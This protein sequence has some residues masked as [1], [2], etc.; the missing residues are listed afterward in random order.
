MLGTFNDPWAGCSWKELGVQWSDTQPP[1]IVF[2]YPIDGQHAALQETLRGQGV[3]GAR[4]AHQIA[5]VHPHNDQPRHP[6]ISNVIV[7]ASG[8]GGV[9]KSTVATHLALALHQEGA[10]VGLL[11][12]DIYGPSQPLTMGLGDRASSQGGRLVPL[13]RFGIPVMSLGLLVDANT[14]TIWRGPMATQALQQMFHQSTWPAL[15]YLV[16]DMPPGTGD[17]P[18]TLAQKLPLSAAIL[19]STPQQMAWSDVVRGHAMFAKLSVPV[20]GVVANMA[21]HTCTACGHVDPVFGNA[22]AFQ[23]TLKEAGLPC[24]AEL[25][26]SRSI[27]EASDAGVPLLIS[28]PDSAEA[29]A[30]T[31][32]ARRVAARLSLLPKDRRLNTP[33]RLHTSGH[34]EH[35]PH[36]H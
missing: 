27:Q 21:Q 24:L 19:V 16:V 9:G 6:Q 14:A 29:Q 3:T 23:N 13:E 4:L 2:P 12:A 32:L 15:D 7:V 25:P 1:S 8:K 36:E 18:L 10:R 20:L 33:V 17:I 28:Q 5:P 35:P 22:Q 30:Y 31:H 11:D 26:L 34:K